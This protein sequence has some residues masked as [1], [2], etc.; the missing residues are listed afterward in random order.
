MS[1]IESNNWVSKNGIV[2]PETT[3]QYE[4][5]KLPSFKIK[6]ALYIR[7]DSM[8]L[9]SAENL[10]EKLNELMQDAYTEDMQPTH[11]AFSC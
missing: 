3:S 11:Q 2:R 9:P 4:L 10:L 7:N 8:N 6:L 1:A 5:A